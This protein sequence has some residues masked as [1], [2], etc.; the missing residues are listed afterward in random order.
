L[1]NI[2]GTFSLS[3]TLGIVDLPEGPF[4]CVECDLL[5][6]PILARRKDTVMRLFYAAL[7][8]KYKW[9]PENVNN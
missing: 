6:K 7:S 5:D 8:D 4:I 2:I 1:N 9:R 3:Y